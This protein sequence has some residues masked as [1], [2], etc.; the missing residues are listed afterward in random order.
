MIKKDNKI[1][2]SYIIVVIIFLFITT[3]YLNL[4]DIIHIAGQMD[5]ISYTEISKYAPSL[6]SES[7]II[8][9]HIAQRFLI[10]YLAGLIAYFT[11]ID[12]FLIFKFF[13][14]IFV[15]FFIFIILFY[16]EKNNFNIKEKMLFFSLLFLNPY[17][18]RNHI[19]QPVQAHDM[20]FFCLG[21]IISYLII[22][23]KNKWIIFFGFFPIF[24]RQ[25]AIA[26]F[27]GSLLILLKNK[28]F[29]YSILLTVFFF[30]CLKF[31][32][33]VSNKI[34]IY[35]FSFKYA[36]G[37]INYDF[38]EIEKLIRFL[39]LPLVSFFPLGIFFFSTRR[40]D[41]DKKKALVLL[42]ISLMM[43]VQ[44][45]LAGPDGSLRNVVRISTLCYPIFVSFLFYTFN[46]NNIFSKNYI[47]ISFLIGLFFWSL[48]PTFSIFG[49]FSI[50]RF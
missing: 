3:K 41:I 22:A 50:L 44:P 1:F 49:F 4:Y 9:K 25:T 30:L 32:S 15:F 16:T 7:D 18:V 12:L 20:L 11:G 26:I 17:I 43:I 35:D 24:L 28:K 14:Y 38:S 33:Q 46:L 6:P 39:C 48:H 42:F 37:I 45:I 13:T 29:L 27:V 36:Y 19:F 23:N 8:I 10:P 40:V 21:L 31:I 5:V 47:Y 34:S 2:Y